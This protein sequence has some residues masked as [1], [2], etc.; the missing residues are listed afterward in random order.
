MHVVPAGANVQGVA[1]GR[2]IAP[3]ARCRRTWCG[4]RRPH[5]APRQ[6]PPRS[7]SHRTQPPP[8]PPGAPRRSPEEG[9]R[10]RAPPGHR[11]DL[12]AH[13]LDGSPLRRPGWRPRGDPRRQGVQRRSRDP[14]AAEPGGRTRCHP[15]GRRC[16]RSLQGRGRSVSGMEQTVVL[17]AH[18][19]P[20]HLTGPNPG[21]DTARGPD[22]E[23]PRQVRLTTA[24]FTHQDI[25]SS[26]TRT[27]RT[28]TPR[29]RTGRSTG[30]TAAARHDP[31]RS[32]HL[33]VGGGAQRAP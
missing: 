27:V 7:A 26:D 11:E 28:A 22:P 9:R 6:R 19:R 20:R 25:G 14:G 30:A 10:H 18:R 31:W 21:K 3:A 13:E 33:V 16:S 1:L 29:G 2:G 8:G 24:L 15:R 12:L 4:R 32:P 5:R 23:L 17:G